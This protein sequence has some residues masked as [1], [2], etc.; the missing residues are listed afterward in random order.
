MPPICK[1]P[2]RCWSHW[3]DETLADT[4]CLPYNAR[5]RAHKPLNVKHFHDISARDAHECSLKSHSGKVRIFDMVRAHEN[6]EY[7]EDP[8]A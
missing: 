5:K 4:P 1:R 6:L 3:C 7:Y 2:R 8:S